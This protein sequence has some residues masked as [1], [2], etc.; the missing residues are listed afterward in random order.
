MQKFWLQILKCGIAILATL[1][2]TSCVIAVDSEG[3][4]TLINDSSF[5]IEEVRVAE[6]GDAFFGADLTGRDALFPGEVLVVE[7]DCDDADNSIF[8]GAVE[9]WYD[10]IAQDCD[11]WGD[12]LWSD[13]DQDGDGY[14][15]DGIGGDDCVDTNPDA[16]PG[17][18][19]DNTDGVDNNC[20]GITDGF[21][22]TM[23]WTPGLTWQDIQD[24]PATVVMSLHIEDLVD[25][26]SLE[27]DVI[28]DGDPSYAYNF[29]TYYGTTLDEDLWSSDL[30]YDGC[31]GPAS[32]QTYMLNLYTGVCYVWGYDPAVLDPTNYCRWEDPTLY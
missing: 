22:V 24:D 3:D 9:V 26:H 1:G 12:P 16:Y 30:G 19:E 15:W 17:A 27:F 14:D 13:G 23:T 4:L 10:G 6:R 28:N 11:D 25:S 8:P 32:T 5:I 2:L 31:I 29:F 18:H 21:H 7:L 20:N